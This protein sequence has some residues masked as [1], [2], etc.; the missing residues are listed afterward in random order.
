MRGGGEERFRFIPGAAAA[1]F[2]LSPLVR[3]TRDFALLPAPSRAAALGN[4]EAVAF[5]LSSRL[6]PKWLLEPGIRVTLFELE[7]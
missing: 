4:G 7:L 2:L 6:D 1:G 3:S 5:T